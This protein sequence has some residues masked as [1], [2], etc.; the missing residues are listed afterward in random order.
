M[1][2]KTLGPDKNRAF[3]FIG[4]FPDQ[5][6]PLGP[7]LVRVLVRL[8]QPWSAWSKISEVSE[9]KSKKLDQNWTKTGPSTVLVRSPGFLRKAGAGVE[10]DQTHGPTPEANQ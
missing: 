8:V 6:H 1:N 9:S 4:F 3:D 10:V 7:A 2:P 5:K